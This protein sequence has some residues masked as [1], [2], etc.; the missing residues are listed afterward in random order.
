[1]LFRSDEASNAIATSKDFVVDARR[2]GSKG[3]RVDSLDDGAAI[4]G[5]EGIFAGVEAVTLGTLHNGEPTHILGRGHLH[6]IAPAGDVGFRNSRYSAT[7][8]EEGL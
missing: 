2:I 8:G 6:L 5:A 1:M 7:M 3:A 4:V